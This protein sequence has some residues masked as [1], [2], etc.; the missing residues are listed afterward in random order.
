M[1]KSILN[2]GKTLSKVDQKLINGGVAR[3]C[4]QSTGNQC[5]ESRPWG[6]FCDAGRCLSGGCLWY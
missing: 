3:Y 6:M 2:L 1:K 4:Y 5:C